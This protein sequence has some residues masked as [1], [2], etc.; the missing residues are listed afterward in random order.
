MLTHPQVGPALFPSPSAF[1]EMLHLLDDLQGA[2]PHKRATT[3]HVLYEDPQWLFIMDLEAQTT[4]LGMGTLAATV[5]SGA[6][7]GELVASLLHAHCHTC[8]H[9]HTPP[10]RPPCRP[11]VAGPGD[12][13]AAGGPSAQ[14]ACRLEP[15]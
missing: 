3:H 10:V 4:W 15:H 6:Q 7:Q 11:A 8:S 5:L 12:C 1:Q 14:P 13:R 2:C 9:A